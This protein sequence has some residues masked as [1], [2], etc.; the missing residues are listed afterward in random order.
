MTRLQCAAILF[1]LDGVLVDSTP[2]VVRVWTE[3]AEQNHIAPAKVLEIVHG[4][5]TKEVLQILT[6]HADMNAEAYK[7]ED[8]ISRHGVQPI[9]GAARLLASLPDNRWCVVTSGIGKLARDRLRV[10]GLPI[11]RVLV[12]ADDVANGKPHPEP[13]LK[14]AQ[15]LGMEPGKCV[16]VEDAPNGIRAAHAGGIK[17]IGLA[18]T[19]APEE[20]READVV[21]KT[22]KEITLSIT[23]AQISVEIV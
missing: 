22:L 6:P 16:V 5:R 10:A 14:G 3:W 21:A 9:P 18:T 17:V 20:L 15:L 19:Y 4:R 1:D 23:G 12:S 13:Y 8:G 2:S 7:V 11:P